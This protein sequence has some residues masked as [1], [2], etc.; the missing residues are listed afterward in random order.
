MKAF[1]LLII[2][3]LALP[4]GA[5]QDSLDGVERL[6]EEL[7][8]AHGPSGFEG[9]VRQIVRREFQPLADEIQTDGL[10]SL[11]ARLGDSSA[12]PRIM[13]A[14]HL[15]EVGMMVKHITPG[16]FIKFQTLGGILDQALINQRYLIR[17]RNG[18]VRGVAGLKTP[19]VMSQQERGRLT[20]KD[21]IFI[22]VGATSR[23]DAEQR[24]GIRPGD[25]IA[26]D[27]RFMKLNDPKLYVAKAWDD[28]AGVA[29]AI[30]VLKRL[31]RNPSPNVVFAAATVQEEI[32]LRGAQTSSHIVKPDIGISIEAGVAADYPGIY[33]DEAQERL[34]RGPGIFLIDSSMIPNV[35][36]RDFVI[37]LADEM[38]IPLQLEVISGYGEDGA[39]MQRAYGGAPVVNLTVPTRYLHNHNGV[40]HRDDFDR[41]VELVTELVRRL[42][43]AAVDRIKSFE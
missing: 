11:I 8:N 39:Q 30:E 43:R 40:I 37:D 31:K 23:L 18:M 29:V 15:D 2:S 42:D 5:Q 22:D 34:G 35:K 24:L 36:L 32:G 3:A 14:A 19:H 41:A 33:P 27:S 21:E 1:H 25:P 28:R 12:G 26:P 7:T 9:P 16:G 13:I 4:C 20:P 38:G 17:T 6:L 10:G